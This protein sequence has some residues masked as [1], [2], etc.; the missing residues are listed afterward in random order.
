MRILFPCDPLKRTK[1]DPE[2]ALESEAAIRAGFEQ[3]FFSH[4]EVESGDFASAVRTCPKESLLLRGWMITGEQYSGLSAALEERGAR[5]VTTPAAYE[6][7]HYLPLAYPQFATVTARTRW[8]AGDE[9]AAAWELYQD[10]REKDALIK[11]WVKSA[12]HRWREACFLPPWLRAATVRR[13]LRQFPPRARRPFQPRSRNS[14][15]HAARLSRYG[16]AWLPASR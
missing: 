1:V 12:K 11:D 4:E 10:F 16:Y 13:N 15:I 6:E 9:P 2:F 3:A 14:R 8:I 7:A 5:L